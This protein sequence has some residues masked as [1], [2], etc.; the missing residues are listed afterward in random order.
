VEFLIQ[1]APKVMYGTLAIISAD[2]LGSLA[3]GG[4]KESC[5]SIKMCR[6]CMATKDES[7]HLVCI[8]TFCTF[9]QMFHIAYAHVHACVMCVHVYKVCDCACCVLSV[10]GMCSVCMPTLYCILLLAVP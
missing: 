5:T 9:C 1:G 6:H 7:Q 8:C 10:S 3:F 4:F 2:N